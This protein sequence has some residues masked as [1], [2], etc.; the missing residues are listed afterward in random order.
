MLFDNL[1]FVKELGKQV[2]SIFFFTAHF[3][4]IVSAYVDAKDLV[5]EYSVV[6]SANLADH[7]LPAETITATSAGLQRIEEK[8]CAL[9]VNIGLMKGVV[10]G[11]G[12]MPHTLVMAVEQVLFFDHTRATGAMIH[13][14]E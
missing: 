11:N 14:F 9:M 8:G 10:F 7:F 3:Q 4:V 13:K 6:P 1:C 2:N 5:T 12:R